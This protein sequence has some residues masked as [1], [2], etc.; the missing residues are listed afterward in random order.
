[1]ELNQHSIRI[2][3]SG[4]VASQCTGMLWTI[5]RICNG[6]KHGLRMPDEEIIFT[7]RTKI[8]SHFQIFRYGRSIFCLPHWPNFSDIF[9]FCLHWV[10]I[11]RGVDY[12]FIFASIKPKYA[13][14]L[15]RLVSVFILVPRL[16]DLISD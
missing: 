14:V 5:L 6:V 13:K 9:E 2:S 4:P 3:N 8:H 12:Q 10:S 1:M 7:A 11:V 16:K 15:V